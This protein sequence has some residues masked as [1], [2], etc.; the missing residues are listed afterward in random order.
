MQ[1]LGQHCHATRPCKDAHAVGCSLLVCK[2]GV[3]DGTSLLVGTVMR[4]IWWD[5]MHIMQGMP[6]VQRVRTGMHCHAR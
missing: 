4:R 3:Q 5:Q 2:V 6:V 1:H